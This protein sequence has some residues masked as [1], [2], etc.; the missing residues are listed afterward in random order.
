MQS[1]QRTRAGSFYLKDAVTLGE[2]QTLKC[3]Q[4][5][6]EVLKP[7]DGVFGSCPALHVRSEHTRLL[8]N[9]NA[10][11]PGQSCENVVYEPDRWVRIYR[12]DGS[13]AGIYAYA[14]EKKWYKPVKMFLERE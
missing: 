14:P 6:S 13:F 9:G 3:E 2:L 5:L 12:Q 10:F 1:L 11:F 4:R 7:V 8:E